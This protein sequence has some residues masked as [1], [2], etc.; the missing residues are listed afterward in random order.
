M[1]INSNI[2]DLLLSIPET[3][4]APSETVWEGVQHSLKRKDFWRRKGKILLSTAV[5]AVA[6]GFALLF[7]PGK[8]I[9]DTVLPPPTENTGKTAESSLISAEMTEAA[10]YTTERET[11]KNAQ[12]SESVVPAKRASEVC[13]KTMETPDETSLQP[14]AT[15]SE[16]ALHIQTEERQSAEIRHTPAVS[17]PVKQ[18]ESVN[19][20][21]EKVQQKTEAYTAVRILFPSAF[22]PNGDGLNDSYSPSVSEPV[23]QYVMRIYNRSNQLVFQTLHP[24][25]SWDGTFRGQAQPHGAYICIVSCETTSGKHSAKG[26]F[27]L[28]RD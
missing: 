11:C 16:A 9:S 26:E 6:G 20:N 13:S 8:N 22:T 27:L 3:A 17:T 21:T 24:E 5:L 28:L 18:M 4:E 2:R 10:I 23:T 14:L 12:A 7:T 15:E 1:D 25:E 19:T